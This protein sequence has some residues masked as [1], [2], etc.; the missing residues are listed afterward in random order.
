MSKEK[1]NYAEFFN[2][3]ESNLSVHAHDLDKKIYEA[4]NAH[5]KIMRQIT[6][7]KNKL[8][9]LETKYNKIFAKLYHHYRYEYEFK[10]ESKDVAIFYLKKD[11]EFLQINDELNDQRLLVDTLE[12]WMKKANA[13]TFEIKNILEYLKWSS[14]K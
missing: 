8:N 4:P 14:G 6:L 7:E 5:N 3:I 13:I 12:K 10:L 1:F 11:D 9:K 2:E